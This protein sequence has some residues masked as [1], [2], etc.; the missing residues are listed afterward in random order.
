MLV[1]KI[2]L[3]LMAMIGVHITATAPRAPAPANERVPSGFLEVF[4][5]AHKWPLI[6]AKIFWWGSTSAE[7]ISILA[8]ATGSE[9]LL[10]YLQFNGGDL[11]ALECNRSFVLGALITSAGGLGRYLCYRTLGK[12]FTFEM[13]IKKDHHLVTKGPYSVVRHP[14]YTAAA[15]AYFGLFFALAYPGSWV[16]ESGVL[17]TTVGRL[18]FT[19]L[20]IWHPLLVVA[21]FKRSG[22]EDEALHAQFGKEWEQWRKE[23]PYKLIP[24]VY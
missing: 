23:V 13:S 2:P 24:F 15:M 1:V 16:R 9:H 18:L 10:P 19:G 3:L 4:I 11:R 5:S 6:I 7:V 12:Q 21:L 8:I 22:E 17:S 20:C 14:S